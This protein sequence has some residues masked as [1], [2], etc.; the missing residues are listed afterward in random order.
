MDRYP[1]QTFVLEQNEAVLD[2][3]IR[4]ELARGGQVYYLHNRVESIAQCASA[5]MKR[6][7]GAE[8]AIAHGKMN[9]EE[10]GDVMQRMADGE[11]QILVCTTII[12][13]GIDI[14]NVNTLI[15]EDADRLGLAQLHQIR[16]RV[17]RSSRHAFAYLTFRKGRVLTEVA[18]KR[19]EAIRE[20][21]EFGSGFKIA[22]RDLEIRGAGNLLGAEQ[23]GHIVSVGYDMYLKLL[24]E[25]VLEEQGNPEPKAPECTADFDVTANIDKAY[26][27]NGEQRMDLYRRMAAI[28]SREDADELLDEIVDRYGDPPKGVLN[29]IDVA[30]LRSEAAKLGITDLSQKGPDVLFTFVA[31]DFAAVSALCEKP[32]WKARLF[33]QPK[34]RTPLLRL[35]LRNGENSLRAA[36]SLVADL[37]AAR[38]ATDAASHQ[39][40][41]E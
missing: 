7:P 36:G 3:A 35:R 16:G 5:L 6:H 33:I 1:V 37:A 12:E 40:L 31:L 29:L 27:E 39:I 14:P 15:I 24:E 2:D 21:A 38:A 28:R 25:A 32:N 13:T 30:L 20:Y 18:E 41:P 9:E 8:V 23:S 11:V 26:V 17:G 22:M 10:L 34:S 4:R 19:L